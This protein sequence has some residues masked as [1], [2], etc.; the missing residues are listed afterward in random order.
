MSQVAVINY[1]PQHD[2]AALLPEL[3]DRLHVFSHHEL[4]NTEKLAHYEYVPDCESVPYP[5]LAI[6]RLATRHTFSHLLTD[7][8]YDLERAARIREDLGIPGQSVAGA[9]SFRDKAV[10]KEVAS[11]A[12]RTARF[13]RLGT[14]GDLIDFIWGQGYPV[15]VKPVKQGGSRGVAVLRDEDDLTGFS[16][17]HWRD[18]LIVEEFVEGRMYHVDAVLAPGYRFVAASRYLRS[19]L[20]VFTGQNNGSVQLHPEE[21]FAVRLRTFLGLVL[22]VFDTPETGAYHLEVFHTPDDELVLCE[23]ASR[24]GGNRIPA[25]TRA[26][27]GVDLHS[28]WLRLSLGL[29][30]EPPPVVPPAEVHGSVSVLPQGRPVRAPGRPPFDWVRHYEVNE[31]LAPGAVAQD[32]TS[33][34]CSVIVAGAD[35]DQVEE[36]LY[37]AEAWLMAH[38]EGPDDEDH[39]HHEHHEDDEHHEARAA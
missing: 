21:P 2:Y 22:D 39:E 8:E 27:Y 34:L 19:C 30:V 1:G 10:M 28:T 37:E 16:R 12:V 24:V 38:L 20:G 26:T 17:R 11:A 29:P 18:D 9:L 32:S 33:Y 14:F 31:R 23:I 36:R 3:A 4:K 6:R 15:V 35:S 5:E 13:A 7:N 25:L